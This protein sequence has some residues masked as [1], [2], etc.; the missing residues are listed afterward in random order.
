MNRERSKSDIQRRMQEHGP[1]NQ[2]SSLANET[3]SYK[4]PILYSYLTADK[5]LKNNGA[6]NNR[7]NKKPD[8]NVN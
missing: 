1:T 7:K 5:T 4:T 8:L 6:F 3:N 2:G